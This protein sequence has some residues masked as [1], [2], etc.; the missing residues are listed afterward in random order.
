MSYQEE[1]YFQNDQYF[2]DLL[3]SIEEAQE[4]IL[5]ESYIYEIDEVG[6]AF[7]RT[8]KRAV[9]RG[10]KVQLLVDGIGSLDWIQ[11][12]KKDLVK[13]GVLVRVFHPLFFSHFVDEKS[14]SE[15]HFSGILRVNLVLGHLNNRNHRK[16]IIIDRKIVFTG[17]L[18]ISA[19]HSRMV[20]SQNAWID[21]GIRLN[22][23]PEIENL[24]RSHQR[25][26]GRSSYSLSHLK[27]DFISRV[28]RIGLRSKSQIRQFILN[29]TPL[30]RRW[31]GKLFRN[32]VRMSQN[33]V[34]LVSPYIAPARGTLRELKRA[35]RRGVDVR[36]VTSSKSDVFF[37]PWVASAHYR[38]L[39]DAGVKIYEESYQFIHAKS[40]IIDDTFL[41]GSSN[42]NQRS[43]R[44]DLELDVLVQKRENQMELESFFKNLFRTAQKIE[45]ADPKFKS[46][47]GRIF[48]F[49]VKYWI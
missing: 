22:N 2:E 11:T 1:L 21:I 16:V 36:I 33:R 5:F 44:H 10:V 24:L 15:A 6:Q 27:T 49:F 37:M 42:L 32:Q 28:T 45:Q 31:A 23:P 18:N 46:F 14:Q 29:D 34:W 12:Q 41:V 3:K 8:L 25:A 47:L 20:K 19:S 17:S 39:L 26:W 9:E 48:L 35:S 7:D 43:L 40:L 38:E 13:S 4:E 30:K